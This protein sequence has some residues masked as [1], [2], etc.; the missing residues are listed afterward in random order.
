[1]ERSKL[2]GDSKPDARASAARLLDAHALPAWYTNNS[3]VRR[4]Y[5]PVTPNVALCFKSWC[6]VHN[7]SA[8]IYTHLVPAF[9]ALPGNLL[10]HLY[11]DVRYP[12]ASRT[13]RLI[14]HIYITTSLICFAM[15]TCYHTLLCHSQ[16]FAALW[17]RIDYVGITV[18]I[19]GS[20]ISGIYMGF[21]C[22]PEL[23]RLHWSIVSEI[24]EHL[25]T[26]LTMA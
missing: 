9:I 8:N 21:Y 26:A 19:L 3:F 2:A 11:M 15:S 25:K 16:H 12:K 4:G 23:R 7:E 6:F 17:V 5:R 18:Q 24:V 13:D 22:E 14:F 10:L 1:M 20:F